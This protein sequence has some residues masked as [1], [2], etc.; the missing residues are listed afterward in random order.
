MNYITSPIGTN[1]R[2]GNCLFQ[3]AAVLSLAKENNFM[4]L[5]PHWEYRKHFKNK[6]VGLWDAN[7][8]THTYIEP[9]FHYTPINL[10]DA[11][12]TKQGQ[13]DKMFNL[14]GY[15]QSERYFDAHKRL[16]LDAF[17]PSEEIE[18]MCH[19]HFFYY[20]KTC[21]IHIRR[22]DYVGNSFYSELK[23]GY[24]E[25]AIA[26]M[27]EHEK[28]EKFM[29]FSDDMEFCKRNF[30]NADKFEY[31]ENNKDIEDLFLMAQCDHNIIAN[32]SFSWWASYLNVN[33][34]KVVIAPK[35]WF[36]ENTVLDTKD[37]YLKEWIT[38]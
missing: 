35:K 22:G 13:Q 2:L 24:Y 12:E 25:E 30:G 3:I 18:L 26:Y 4:P 28:V 9:Y 20:P 31:V 8:I 38:L 1:G 36:G 37:L 34:N 32:S 15:F 27:E 19:Q 7:Q 29:M 21:S 17:A 14:Q 16:I 33:P 10:N 11:L 6:L 23:K 5:F